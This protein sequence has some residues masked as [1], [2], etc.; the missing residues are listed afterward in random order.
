MA[1][2]IRQWNVSGISGRDSIFEMTC[3]LLDSNI[4]TALEDQDKTGFELVT[5]RLASLADDDDACIS[6]LTA[7]EYQHGIARAPDDL[8]DDLRESWKSFEDIFRIVPLSLEG[9]KRYGE[10]KVAYERH[11]GVGR[12]SLQERTVD[13][14]LAS[15]ALEI[16]AVVVSDDKVFR[17]LQKID[18]AIRAENWKE[19]PGATAK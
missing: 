13:L 15:T 8:K 7:Y 17:T 1:D 19:P 5:A 3:Y 11:T 9:A 2:Q 12:R 14:I 16:G 18:P 6:I 10:L 4:V